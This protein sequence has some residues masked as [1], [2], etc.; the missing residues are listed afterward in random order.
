MSTDGADSTRR[1][2]RTRTPSQAA[3]ASPDSTRRRREESDDTRR[4]APQPATA[5]PTLAESVAARLLFDRMKRELRSMR[6]SRFEDEVHAL[7]CA[8]AIQ[9]GE[10]ALDAL[11]HRAAFGMEAGPEAKRQLRTWLA[12]FD[13]FHALHPDELPNRQLAERPRPLGR[14]QGVW[15]RVLMRLLAVALL[16]VLQ[17]VLTGGEQPTQ[18]ADRGQREKLSLQTGPCST[19]TPNLAAVRGGFGLYRSAWPPVARRRAPLAPRWPASAP[20]RKWPQV[21]IG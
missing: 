18:Q 6:K 21:L 9:S 19:E 7:A 20:R 17:L 14:E 15:P 12:R 5:R 11:P 16:V 4:A 2:K 10:F 3:R 13:E 1:S 8:L